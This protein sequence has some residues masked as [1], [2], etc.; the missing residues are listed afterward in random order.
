MSFKIVALCSPIPSRYDLERTLGLLY[1]GQVR[2]EMGVALYPVYSTHWGP[3]QSGDGLGIISEV[4][5]SL[6]A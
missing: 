3:G 6:G 4:Q 2:V 1:S 5:H